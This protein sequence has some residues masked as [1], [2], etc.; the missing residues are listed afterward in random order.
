MTFFSYKLRKQ[1]SKLKR[2]VNVLQ[3]EKWN[4]FKVIASMTKNLLITWR[5]REVFLLYRTKSNK[6]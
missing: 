6:K 2:E 1:E 4:D 5:K 3:E